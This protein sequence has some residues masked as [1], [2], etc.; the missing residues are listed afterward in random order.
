MKGTS[1]SPLFNKL[2]GPLKPR[3][4]SQCL[5]HFKTSIGGTTLGHSLRWLEGLSLGKRKTLHEDGANRFCM[6]SNYG[7]L[8]NL[9]FAVLP[10]TQ[11]KVVFPTYKLHVFLKLL[12]LISLNRWCAVKGLIIPIKYVGGK[13]RL[14][15][16][17]R[18]P[19]KCC[20]ALSLSQTL[21][22]KPSPISFFLQEACRAHPFTSC[23]R[24]VIN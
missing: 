13:Y 24:C 18:P 23:I 16:S 12:L 3:N 14:N 1:H 20:S 9:V 15:E 21:A 19:R 7:V 4:L 2:V 8:W 17:S 22:L 11:K 6:V 10:H 5:G